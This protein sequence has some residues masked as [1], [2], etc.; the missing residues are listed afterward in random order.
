MPSLNAEQAAAQAPELE[1]VTW[2]DDAGPVDALRG[3]LERV[4]GAAARRTGVSA[5]AK[6]AKGKPI[7]LEK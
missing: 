6:K 5:A 2:D 1:L 3:M 7:P 4:G